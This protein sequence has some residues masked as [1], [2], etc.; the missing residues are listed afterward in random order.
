MDYSIL[1]IQ[2]GSVSDFKILYE[3]FYPTLCVFAYKY[4]K[5]QMLAEDVVQNTFIKYWERRGN[6]DNIYK[7]KSFF[8]VTVKNEC[9]NLIRDHKTDNSIILDDVESLDFFGQTLIEEESFRIFYLAVKALPKQCYK[10]INLA[11]EGKKNSEIAEELGISEGTVHKQ[12][13]ISYKK[14]RLLLKD[15]YHL[16]SLFLG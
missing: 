16:I 9:L 10:I 2:N 11:L 3:K 7:V 12:K 13:K 1:N 8:Y 5:N 4:L 15:N 6:F 14:L